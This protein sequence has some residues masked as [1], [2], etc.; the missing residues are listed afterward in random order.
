MPNIYEITIQSEKDT[1]FMAVW[2]IEASIAGAAISRALCNTKHNR[3]KD[4]RV[5]CKLLYKNMT[6]KEYKAAKE[7]GTLSPATKET[8]P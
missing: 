5:A 3:A 1:K 2:N 8:N 7:A 4:V 6:M